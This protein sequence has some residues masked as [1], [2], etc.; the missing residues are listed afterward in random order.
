MTNHQKYSTISDEIKDD[1][2]NSHNE[3][4]IAI[5]VPVDVKFQAEI[6]NTSIM[7]GKMLSTKPLS[8][9]NQ[10]CFVNTPNFGI[11][12]RLIDCMLNGHV[13]AKYVALKTNINGSKGVLDRNW[14][15]D[16]APDFAWTT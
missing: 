14:L 9:W 16:N 7:V 5:H 12:F 13:S 11:V 8:L 1:L 15:I 2:L 6:E 3:Q 10:R 4:F